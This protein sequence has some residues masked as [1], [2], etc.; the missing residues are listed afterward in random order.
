[1]R[2]LS[3]LLQILFEIQGEM[4]MGKASPL[5]FHFCLKTM[6]S[7]MNSPFSWGR[8]NGWHARSNKNQT[9]KKSVSFQSVKFHC[10]TE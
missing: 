10:F 9:A 4:H 3:T 8:M 6:G 2:W 1:M 7:E 5:V